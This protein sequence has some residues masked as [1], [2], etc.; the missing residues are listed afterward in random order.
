MSYASPHS[1]VQTAAVMHEANDKQSKG[2]PS[3]S[4]AE[5]FS[6][7]G[8]FRLALEHIGG[9]CVFACEYCR[10]AA[11]TYRKNWSEDPASLLVGDICRIVPAQIPPHDLLVAGFPCQDFSNA[12]SLQGFNGSSG[13]L[14]LEL[15]RLLAGCQ[16]HA[17][18]L[19]NVRGL[20]T[21][22]GILDEV[23]SK[24]ASV[25]YIVNVKMID[26]AHL[27]PQTRKRV[28]IVGFRRAS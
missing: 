18:L 20:L 8:G 25:G 15:V 10:F 12:G 2:G 22:T 28:Y 11:S 7:I 6:G 17:I 14:F 19:E 1:L 5:V 9:R 16:P 24:L 27:L 13:G 3:F 21:R 26:A 4:F 23:K